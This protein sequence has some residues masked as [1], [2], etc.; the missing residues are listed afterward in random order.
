MRRA[1]ARSHATLRLEENR[2][3]KLP[4]QERIATAEEYDRLFNEA[5]TDYADFLREEE[6]FSVRD[7]DE[8]ALRERIGRFAPA[9][10]L[11][12]F[13]SEVSYR[14]PLT[15][16]THGHHWMDLAMMAHEP[17]P[18]PIR[19]VPSLYNIFDSRAEGM[20]TGM[21]EW[22]MH[23]GLFDDRPRSREL[24]LILVAQRAARAIGGLMM[25][26]NEWTIDEAVEFASKWTPRGWMP[27]DGDTVWG[28]QHFYLTQPG[29]STSYLLGKH[30][31]EQLMAERALQLGDEFTLK[32]FIDEIHAAG[33]IPMSLIRWEMTGEDDEISKL[34]ATQ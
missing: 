15:M 20:A 14:D 7:Y 27:E 12:G 25:H 17:H 1:L 5:V 3:R 6:I 10:G 23:A 4:R 22:M 19:R 28:E 29:Y 33:L 21:E 31:I 16:R 2:N 8:G 11:R 13:F 24:M 9:E 26:A 30:Q 32:G 34:T 18:S